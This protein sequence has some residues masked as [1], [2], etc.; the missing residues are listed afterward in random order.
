VC[1]QIHGF[2]E[3]AD[4]LLKLR[5]DNRVVE[6]W[7][8]ETVTPTNHTCFPLASV[9]LGDAIA[10]QIKMDNRL[11]LVTV[12]GT[13]QSVNVFQSDP[14]WTNRTFYFKEGN[15][16]QD[17][18]GLPDEGAVVSFYHLSVNHSP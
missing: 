6:A 3:T 10:Y 11:R 14:L 8:K 16:C 17:N 15:Y 7:V 2:N 5:Y 13:S 12:N 4:P 18:A 9:D 1:E